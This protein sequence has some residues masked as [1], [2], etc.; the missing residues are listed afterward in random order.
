MG[1][2]VLVTGGSGIPA[3]AN[4]C[5]CACAHTDRDAGP[6]ASAGRIS[7]AKGP[8]VPSLGPVT[9][10][11]V[12]LGGLPLAALIVFVVGV[13]ALRPPGRGGGRRFRARGERCW[14]M[15]CLTGGTGFIGSHLVDTL[16][17]R[18]YR[19]CAL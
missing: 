3:A 1:E 15:Q 5:I 11:L 4:T 7:S 13:L 14:E 12:S 10:L 18:G 6:L 19:V 9:L 16:V 17:M 2:R 8:A